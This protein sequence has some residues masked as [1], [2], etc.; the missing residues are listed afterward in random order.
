VV[1]LSGLPC[2]WPTTSVTPPTSHTQQARD[3]LV[4][5][6]SHQGSSNPA[7]ALND[8]L[9]GATQVLLL[10]EF[11]V[12]LGGAKA[13]AAAQAAAAAAGKGS[14]GAAGDRGNTAAVAAAGG[15]GEAVAKK[16]QYL[17]ALTVL[18]VLLGQQL[19]H[20]VLQLMGVLSEAVECAVH[21]QVQWQAVGVW[22][23]LIQGLAASAP[24]LLDRVAAQAAVVLLPLVERD[25]SNAEPAAA[26]V[27]GVRVSGEGGSVTS[28]D[29]LALAAHVLRELVVV[30]RP[31]VAHALKEMPPLPE[32]PIL[33][34]V[35][36]VLAEVCGLC[37]G[38]TWWQKHVRSGQA[39]PAQKRL[40]RECSCGLP[41]TTLNQ[42]INQARPAMSRP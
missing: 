41:Y 14:P 16:L 31:H 38:Y 18:I 35:N 33:K 10:L 19:K 12:V 8:L 36:A 21:E 15:G 40:G 5:I 25:G 17:R 29:V 13:R 37:V 24:E 28:S 39:M 4:Q 9:Q 32:L 42:L 30:H 23:V 34:E 11:G 27:A 7:A 2:F 1:L 3:L 26:A 22:L 6:A 20:H